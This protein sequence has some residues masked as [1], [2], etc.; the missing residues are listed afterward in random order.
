MVAGSA[1]RVLH[2]LGTPAYPY[3]PD[4]ESLARVSVHA[5]THATHTATHNPTRESSDTAKK[6]AGNWHYRR[7]RRQKCK[8]GRA[9]HRVGGEVGCG[10]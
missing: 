9:H 3:F 6:P 2:K 4:V 7:T 5:A 1:I 10:W 8:R